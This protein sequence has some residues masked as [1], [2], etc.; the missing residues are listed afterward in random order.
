MNTLSDEDLNQINGLHDLWI[1]K[2]LEGDYA[3]VVLLC[4]E[5]IQW[6]PPDSPPIVSKEEIRSYLTRHQVKLLSVD[7]T[8]LF[9]RGDTSVAYLTSNYCTRYSTDSHSQ[10]VHEARGTHLWI[11]R[12]ENSEWRVA[13]LTWSS[14]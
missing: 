1:A 3:A 6:L 4:T 8:D 11:L 2:E 10:V 14:W 7:A 9:V 5:D 13:I 12:K